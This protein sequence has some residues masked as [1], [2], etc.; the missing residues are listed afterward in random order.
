MAATSVAA[1]SLGVVVAAQDAKK[2]ALSFLKAKATIED[3]VAPQVIAAAEKEFGTKYS[4]EEQ[5]KLK[6]RVW[7]QMNAALLQS[8][9]PLESR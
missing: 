2:P 5:R 8:Y 7:D 9:E 4:P 6:A 1:V 3:L